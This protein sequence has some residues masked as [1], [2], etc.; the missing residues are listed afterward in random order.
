MHLRIN[1]SKSYA[2]S[3]VLNCA[4]ELFGVKRFV[5][6]AEKFSHVCRVNRFFFGIT[7]NYPVLQENKIENSTS[8]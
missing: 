4:L 3:F 2:D 7:N 5:L 8:F 1:T 6:F